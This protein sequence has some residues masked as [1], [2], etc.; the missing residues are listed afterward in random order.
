M[1]KVLLWSSIVS[2]TCFLVLWAIVG[3]KLLNSNYEVVIEGYVALALLI[4]CLIS[5]VGYKLSASKCPH[6]GKTH[7]T[8]GKY[9]S[10]CGKELSN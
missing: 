8:S 4:V 2:I 3:L 1:K 5:I 6:C 10:Y 7:L 9:C